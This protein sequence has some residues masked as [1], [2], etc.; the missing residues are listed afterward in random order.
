M[1]TLKEIIWYGF[2][3]MLWLLLSFPSL[4]WRRFLL[5]L[6]GANV[7]RVSI[8]SN[9][10][11]IAPWKLEIG[12]GVTINSGVFLDSRGGIC[13]GDDVMVGYN[14][15]IHSIGHNYHLNGF[16]VFKK[17]V[18]IY[19]GTIIYSHCYIGPGVSINENCTLLPGTFIL[20]STSA[21]NQVYTG[22]PCQL[23]KTLDVEIDR[24]PQ[25]N[26]SPLG[27]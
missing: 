15:A 7:G 6:F 13:I 14:T 21:S 4:Y 25:Y 18:N 20:K 17:Q 5:N 8:M 19:K 27:F 24:G 10:K 16:P 9:L 12:N 11:V 23:I 3:R 1:Y 22:N 26:S 2:H